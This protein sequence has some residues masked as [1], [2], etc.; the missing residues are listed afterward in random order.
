MFTNNRNVTRIVLESGSPRLGCQHS[1][2]LVIALCPAAECQLLGVASHGGKGVVKLFAVLFIR[3]LILFMQA[4]A[5]R[6][7]YLSRPY[8]HIPPQWR[9]G[10]QQINLWGIQ[11][12]SV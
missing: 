1:W 10:L 12:F 6:P 7:N 5:K 11:T 9:L 3:A 8:F 2:D 4:P